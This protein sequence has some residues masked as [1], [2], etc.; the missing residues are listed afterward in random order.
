MRWTSSD[1]D[2]VRIIEEEAS[3]GRIKVIK[4]G[5]NVKITAAACDGSDVVSEIIIST[6]DASAQSITLD[7]KV[8]TL[9]SKDTTGVELNASILP[10]DLQNKEVQWK[11][12]KTGIVTY[13]T[14][15]GDLTKI[16]IKPVS[17]VL[18]GESVIVT[19]SING[20]EAQ[21][22]ILISEIKLNQY[23]LHNLL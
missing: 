15:G 20:K 18:P 6:K 9:G 7:K 2:S 4:K 8:I 10:S 3:I 17:G 14:T 19:A 22:V 12:S 5:G 13:E 16:R 11:L 23:K 21:C 1:P